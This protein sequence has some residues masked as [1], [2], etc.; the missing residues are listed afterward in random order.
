MRF[1]KP[2]SAYAAG[3]NPV[4]SNQNV[5]DCGSSTR[6]QVEVVGFAAGTISVALEHQKYVAMRSHGRRYRIE[7]L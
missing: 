5:F 1:T 6:R 7:I 2:S 4:I 3:I